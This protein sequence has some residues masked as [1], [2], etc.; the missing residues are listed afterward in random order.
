MTIVMGVVALV[1]LVGAL[2][3]INS[4]LKN[5]KMDGFRTAGI[6]AMQSGDYAGAIQNFDEA[7]KLAGKKLGSNEVDILQRRA[8]AAYNMKDYAGALETWKTLL[9]KDSEN[10]DYKK[11]LVL[12]MMETG[13][14]E[15]ALQVGPMQ[16]KI[17]NKMALDK[18][19][20]GDYEGALV[21]I[22]Q[23]L[24]VDDGSARADLLY[25]QAVAHENR[26]N[27][28][29]ALELFQQYVGTYGMDEN[30]QKEIEFLQT[31]VGG[32]AAPAAESE[33]QEETEAE[34]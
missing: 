13:Q 8:E 32:S 7:M 29:Q 18:I 27:Y 28:V 10:E 1:V 26:G 9:A 30:V 34:E 3:G 25:N 2:V 33:A 15:E 22:E 24:G 11:N 31:R 12:C 20:A 17:Y 14:Y 21:L 23:G 19:Q 16:S 4:H 6:E 5:K